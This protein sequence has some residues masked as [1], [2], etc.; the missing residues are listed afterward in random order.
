MASSATA[1]CSC[2]G[3]SKVAA[4]IS[5]PVVR[6]QSVTSSGRSSTSTAI[7]W[8]SGWLRVIALAMWCRIVVLPALG[9]ATIRARWP[10]PIGIIRS[11]TR[12]VSRSLSVSSRSRSCG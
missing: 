5:A 12:V 11:M 2:G 1:V 8:Q 6:C 3:R 10:L 4:Q 7:R 9:G